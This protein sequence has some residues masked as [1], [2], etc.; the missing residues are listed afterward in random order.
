MGRWLATRRIR[1][2]IIII[3]MPFLP[4]PGGS[5][6]VPSAPTRILPMTGPAPSLP[7][8]GGGGGGGAE[9]D[10]PPEPAAPPCGAAPDA[11]ASSSTDSFSFGP[12][13]PTTSAYI[14]SSLV[15]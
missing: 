2:F 5:C 15:S 10:D 4:T 12:P 14:G 9:A 6:G 11:V 3:I 8:G 1:P 13:L 7:G